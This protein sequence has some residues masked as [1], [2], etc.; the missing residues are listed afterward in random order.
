[1]T[2]VITEA[3]VD[4]L[5]LSCTEVCPVDCIHPHRRDRAFGTTRQLYINPAECI[6]CDACLE[7]CPVEAIYPEEE[8]PPDLVRDAALNRDYFRRR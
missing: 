6:D 3:C 5:D 4:I 2:F 1:M 7:V 8:L